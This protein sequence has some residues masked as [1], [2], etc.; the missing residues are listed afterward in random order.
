MGFGSAATTIIFLLAFVMS[1]GY[2]RLILRR[3]T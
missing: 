2:I 1:V 3:E